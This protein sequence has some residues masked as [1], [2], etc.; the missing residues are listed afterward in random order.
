MSRFVILSGPSCVGTGPLYSALRKFYPHLAGRLQ[1]IVLYNS[2]DPR[3]GEQEGV[4][5][6][7]RPRAR[8]EELSKKPGFTSAI[9]RGDLQAVEIASIKKI[10]DQDKDAFFEG[11]PFIPAKLSECKELQE[12][13]TLKVFLSPL[14]QEE[15]LFLKDPSQ[16]TNLEELLPDIM[17]RKLLRRTKRQKINL[18]LKDLENI[19]KRVASAVVELR[20]AWKFD[21][22]IPNHDGEDSEH[23]DAFYYP[24]GDARKAL[25]AFAALLQGEI[26]PGVEYWEKDFVPEPDQS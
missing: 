5:Y 10:L 11:N 6:Y 22:V 24:I 16:R 2:R 14:S 7:F 8:I 12:I 3:P 18:S 15:I 23:W 13:P 9:V 20:E 4:D 17:R 25:L 21:Y 1:Q 26:P 19:E